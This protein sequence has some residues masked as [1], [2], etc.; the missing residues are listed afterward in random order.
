MIRL[1]V[2]VGR[3]RSSAFCI[4]GERLLELWEYV[5]I[6]EVNQIIVVINTYEES[7][8]FTWII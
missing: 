2:V 1:V 7:L 5:C 6:V 3:Q 4:E 8:Q